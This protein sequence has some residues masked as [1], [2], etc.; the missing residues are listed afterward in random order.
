MASAEQDVGRLQVP[1]DDALGMGMFQRLS[2]LPGD[3]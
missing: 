1:V 2:A 3:P